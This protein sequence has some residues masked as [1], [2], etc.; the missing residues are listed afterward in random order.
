MNQNPLGTQILELEDGTIVYLRRAEVDDIP[1]Y[2]GKPVALVTWSEWSGLIPKYDELIS[3]SIVHGS[4]V[5]RLIFAFS[6][7]P[8]LLTVHM[9]IKGDGLFLPSPGYPFDQE[10]LALL[11]AK[12]IL[13]LSGTTEGLEEINGDKLLMLA[14]YRMRGGSAR[15]PI[16]GFGDLAVMDDMALDRYH[17]GFLWRG[18]SGSEDGVFFIKRH[19]IPGGLRPM[20]A[21]RGGAFTGTT[22]E[23][24][25]RVRYLGR[26]LSLA[27]RR[28]REHLTFDLK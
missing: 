26:Y 25:C 4:D 21:Y 24:E 22:E 2:E 19:S 11:V 16:T 23:D 18:P 14:T 8:H 6:P 27:S 5:T 9:M 28:K 7:V 17:V 3:V 1:R 13:D 10:A 12:L 15:S 20:K